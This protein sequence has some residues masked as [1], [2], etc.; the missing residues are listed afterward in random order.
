MLPASPRYLDDSRVHPSP[1]RPALLSHASCRLSRS[2]LPSQG[3][4]LAVLLTTGCAGSAD[5]GTELS[6]DHPWTLNGPEVRIGSLDDPDYL[7]GLVGSV[8]PGPDGFVYSLHPRDGVVRRWTA[9]GTPAG[10]IGRTGEGPGEF[11]QP[12]RMGFFGD[13][14]WVMDSGLNRASYF[15]LA[16]EFL[17]SASPDIS[18]VGP[19][20]RA[21]RPSYPLRDGTFVARPGAGSLQ[22]ATG[23][24]TENPLMRV[25]AEGDA[26]GTIWLEPF[27]PLDLLALLDEG[28]RGGMFSIQA[29]RDA[30]LR[31]SLEHGLLVVD[32]AAWTGS[33][34]ATI[35]ITG[36]DAAGDTMFAR[37]FP[38]TPVPLASER[39][40]SVVRATTERLR[41]YSEGDVRAAT[42]R[43]SHVPPVGGIVAGRDGTIWLRHFDSTTSEGGEEVYE[44]W[45]LDAEGHPLA[46]AVTPARLRLRTILS[47]AVWGVERDDLD[48]EYIV[49]YRLVKGD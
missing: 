28:G 27:K 30:P 14:L 34:P 7:F 40:D 4:A 13:S 17:G 41:N 31:A 9:D 23:E 36:I 24:L 45:V 1:S 18:L 8:V 38:Y 15:D 21:V 44:W 25:D 5:S 20:G 35:G 22:I 2:A 43:P 19:N 39:V 16:G 32:R 26:L 3:I 6:P 46:R 11:T 10:T 48:V 33:G 47:D 12:V 29:F 49:R 42:Y 37:S